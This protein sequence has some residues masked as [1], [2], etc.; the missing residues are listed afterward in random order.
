MQACLLH[1]HLKNKAAMKS[2]SAFLSKFFLELFEILQHVKKQASHNFGHATSILLC[3]LFGPSGDKTIQP[4]FCLPIL[5]DIWT[6]FMV[7]TQ[8]REGKEDKE[9]KRGRQR[10]RKRGRQREGDRGQARGQGACEKVEFHES[11]KF[12]DQSDRLT[13]RSF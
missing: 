4:C 3:C 5:I 1:F 7:W 10:E 6:K 13:A 11:R 2:I 9:R 12:S 8:R